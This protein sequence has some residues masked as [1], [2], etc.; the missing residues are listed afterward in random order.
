MRFLSKITLKQILVALAIGAIS[1][2]AFSRS[3]KEEPSKY[4]FIIAKKADIVQQVSVTGQVKPIKE[5]DLAFENSGKIAQVNVDIGDKIR[6]GEILLT[7]KSGELQAELLQAQA[8]L[9]REKARLQEAQTG[10]RSEEIQVQKTK[11]KKAQISIQDAKNNLID[12]IR[13]AYTQADYAIRNQADQMFQNAQTN[14]PQIIFRPNKS[15]M[16]ID[17]N[18]ARFLIGK[19]L[20]SWSND[21]TELPW[22]KDFRKSGKKAK[23]NCLQVKSLLDNL[24]FMVND[25]APNAYISTTTIDNWGIDIATARTNINTALA[26]LSAA[27]EK[28]NTAETTF[29]VSKKELSLAQSG[30]RPEQ[31][32]IYGAEVKS[33]EAQVKRIQAKLAETVLRSPING[34]ITKQEA[35]TGAI[36]GMNEILISLMG[37]NYEIEA[38]VP[39]VD[40]AKVK[41]DDTV[42]ITFDALEE[43]IFMGKVRN[44]NPAETM[45]QGVVYYEVKIDFEEAIKSQNILPGMTA[46]LEIITGKRANV[47]AIPQRAVISSEGIKSVQ[48]LTKD[49]EDKEI[50]QKITIKTGLRGSEGEVEVL[51]GIEEG[52]RVVTAVKN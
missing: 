32:S 38:N 29:N 35:K 40:I 47:L 18:E 45:V 2:Y 39:E 30:T 1:V 16:R 8:N 9:E 51:E 15:Q 50:A 46:D 7:L 23:A 5:V 14:N 48:I 20:K 42:E 26:N 52:D 22:E 25:L 31:I 13:E 34:V 43:R 41:I 11:V 19:M 6:K 44:T 33:A 21:L 12:K 4:D 49:D 36:V 37:E 17:A 28:L 3:Q 10:T 24:A 27:E